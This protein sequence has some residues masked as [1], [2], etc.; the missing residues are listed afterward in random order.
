MTSAIPLPD[1]SDPL[2]EPHWAAAREGRLAM[3]RCA[4]CRYVRWPAAH[5]CPECLMEGGAWTT[6]S[7]AGTIW[8]YVVYEQALHPAFEGQTPYAVGLIRLDEGP[9][10]HGRL[11]SRPDALACGDRVRVVF[12]ELAPGVSVPRFRVE[13]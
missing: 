8:S 2:T 10:I 12:A 7:G 3:Q 6:L 1:M 5:A 13:S 9:M 4:A 11:E